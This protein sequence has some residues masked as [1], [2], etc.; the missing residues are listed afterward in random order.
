MPLKVHRHI[1]HPTII[2]IGIWHIYFISLWSGFNILIYKDLQIP[3]S[4]LKR[5]SKKISAHTATICRHAPFIVGTPITRAS[6]SI[7]P[8]RSHNV[9]T[10]RD[11]IFILIRHCLRRFYKCRFRQPLSRGRIWAEG[12]GPKQPNC[13]HKHVCGGNCHRKRSPFIGVLGLPHDYLDFLH[14]KVE[15]T[16]ARLLL[17]LQCA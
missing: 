14:A 11:T 8:S 9:L 13:H 1:A 4:S 16:P 12:Q 7:S 17:R 2:D 6:S 15:L 10:I 5:S 3:P